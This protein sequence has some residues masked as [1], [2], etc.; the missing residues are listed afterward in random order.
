MSIDVFFV[1]N[2]KMI[3]AIQLKKRIAG[4]NILGIIIGKFCRWQKFS[5]VILFRVDK[6]PKVDFYC[7]ILAFCLTIGLW[8]KGGGQF[9]LDALKIA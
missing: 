6:G 9:S 1:E 4:T 8:I 5:P 2:A 3:C 7:T